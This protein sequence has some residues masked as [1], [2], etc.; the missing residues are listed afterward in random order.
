[1]KKAQRELKEVLAG[2]RQIVIRVRGRKTGRA[3]SY[4]VWF[5][6]EGSR[7]YLLPVH[8]TETQWYRNLLRHPAISIAAR[9]ANATLRGKP[10]R[11]AAAV[12]AVIRKFGQ[13]Y[14]ARVVRKLY[15]KFDAAVRVQF[16]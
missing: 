11:R 13:K 9:G 2:A 6:L 1:M 14:K 16:A 10:I 12:K 15:F 8:G 7:L 3:Y 4:P 5:V